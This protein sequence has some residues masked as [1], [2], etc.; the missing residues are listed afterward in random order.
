MHQHL[1]ESVHFHYKQEK[2]TNESLMSAT[3]E[4][5]TEWTESKVSARVKGASV[6]EHK[7]EGTTKLKARSIHSLPFKAI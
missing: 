7:E 4:A 6:A 1:H 5:E 3:H 2:T